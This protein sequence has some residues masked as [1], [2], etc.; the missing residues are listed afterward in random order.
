MAQYFGE[1]GIRAA[2]VHSAPTSA[3]RAQSLRD[4]RVGNLEVICAVDVFNEGLDVP[5]I[6]TVLML[7][8]TESPVIFLQQLGRG[9]RRAD[10]KDALVVIDFIGN[11]RSFLTKPQSLLFLLG[12]DLP[13]RVA[14]EKI[15]TQTLTL[16]EGCEITIETA[17]IDMLAELSK[18]SSADVAVFEYMRFRDTHGRRPTAP[19]LFAEGVS[20]EPMKKEHE[21]WFHFVRAQGDTTDEEARVLDR[22]AA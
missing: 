12:E 14:L 16:P 11:H 4:L 9:L 8:P 18:A 5:D 19:E 22:H 17:A 3:S 10:D 20:F 15:R 6:N 1:H 13:P 21:S 7:R 2:A